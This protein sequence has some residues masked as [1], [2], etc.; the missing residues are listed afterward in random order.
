MKYG[1]LLVCLY[2]YYSNFFLGVGKVAWKTDRQVMHQISE[3]ANQLGNRLG[4]VMIE[5]FEA[6]QLKMHTREE[7]KK[8]GML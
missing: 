4:S 1:T 2:F 7:S 8:V 3:M 5:H 6:F